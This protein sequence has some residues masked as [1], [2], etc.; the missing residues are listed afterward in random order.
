MTIVFLLSHIPD[1]RYNKRIRE[2]SKI[3][4][5][6]VVCLRRLNMDIF[7]FKK[8]EGV[9]YHIKALFIPPASSLVKRGMS[10]YRYWRFVKTFLNKIG[11]DVIYTNGIDMLYFASMTCN[12]AK[13]CFEVAD[14]REYATRKK[15][16]FT[17]T[18]IADR[19]MRIL[20]KKV[21]KRIQLLIVTSRKFYDV[22][23]SQLIDEDKVLELPN[24][25]LRSAFENY[26]PKNCGPFTVGFVGGL[27]YLKQM[28]MLV[29]AS[30]DLGINIVFAGATDGDTDGSFQEYCK[31]KPWVK[32]SGRYDFTKDIAGIYG[33]LD[34]V[35]SVYD[36]S[37]FNVRIAL[38]NK[39]YEAIICHLPIIVAKNT[40][41]EELVMEW[42]IGISTNYNDTEE[43]HGILSKLKEDK[44]YYNSFVHNC[45]KHKDKIDVQIYLDKLRFRIL[46]L[47]CK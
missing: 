23:Y 4:D 10:A 6:H 3:A 43:L 20:E 7:P 29:D 12:H 46:Q 32:F 30:K 15:S 42:G 14:L 24:M 35:Y 27:R 21:A 44:D 33:A 1:P 13:I 25:P 2:L 39:L 45:I 28:R 19:I 11:P 18:G 38:P 37:N 9:K 16:I 31:D 40:Y 26:I 5:V 41:L 22:Y 36:A 8:I 17:T 34:C 47:L